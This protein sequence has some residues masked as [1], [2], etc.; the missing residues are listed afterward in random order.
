MANALIRPVVAYM[1]AHRVRIP[2]S[3]E[4]RLDM[5]AFE[6][7]WDFWACGLVEVVAEEVGR[8]LTLLV[9]DERERVR[10][11]KR[12]G[13]WNV[14]HATKNLMEV[15]DFVRGVTELPTGRMRAYA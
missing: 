14:Q 7:A 2:L 13:L 3:F 12:I 11:L 1:N 4:A 15:V 9:L 6:G 5:R 8:A 10:H